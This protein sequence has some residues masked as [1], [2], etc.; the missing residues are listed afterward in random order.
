MRTK[1]AT[2]AHDLRLVDVEQVKMFY[3]ANHM[4][5]VALYD[6]EADAVAIPGTVT[7]S[8][9]QKNGLTANEITFQRSDL[10]ADTLSE[11]T[12]L[13]TRRLIAFY[14]DSMGNNRVCG[15][16]TWPMALTFTT[17]VD[18]INVTLKGT[19]TGPDPILAL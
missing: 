9:S 12:R 17:D 16:V 18:G 15:S 10:N 13:R 4:A 19:S 2:V 11:L 7:V 8:S 3:V 14:R 5:N 1:A 6:K